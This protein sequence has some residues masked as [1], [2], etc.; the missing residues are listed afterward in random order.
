MSTIKSLFNYLESEEIYVDKDEFDFQFNSHPDFPSLLALSDTLTFFNIKNGAFKVNKSEIDLLPNKF[1]AK[2]NKGNSDFLSYVQKM[3]DTVIYSNGIAKN[4]VSKT[5]FEALWSDIVLLA[6]NEG[7]PPKAKSNTKH[8]Y[9][10]PLVTLVLITSVIILTSPKNW[11]LF[12]YALPILG[13][14][15]SIAVLKDLLGTKN[16]LLNKFCNITTNTSCNTIV[17]SNKWKI[18]DIISFSDLS[19]IFFSAQLVCLF[20]MGL[21]NLYADYFSI[22][23]IMLISAFPVITVSIYYQKYIEKKWCP[24]CLAIIGIVLL[25]LSA[26][27]YL[28]SNFSFNISA[29]GALLYL[30]TFAL[31]STIWLPLKKTLKKVNDLKAIELKANRFKRNYV[32]FKIMLIATER[33]DLPKCALIFGNPDAMLNISI[34]TS[35]F[36]GYCKEP[37]YMLKSILEKYGEQLNISIFY[38][39]NPTIILLRDFTLTISQ[40]K[41]KKGEESFLEAMDYW[42]KVKDI[43]NRKWFNKYKVDNEINE[44]ERLMEIQRKWFL[45]NSINFTP[46]LFVSGYRY[47]KEYNI[48]DLPFFIEELLEDQSFNN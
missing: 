11:L 5:D 24:L 25:E 7:T 47:P 13:T 4:I 38:N 39:V 35:P 28:N 19:I 34:V 3:N 42:Y 41:I 37:H 8:N 16:E 29:L 9:I 46:C 17:N 48:T 6:E 15:L 36:C 18:F 27:F 45:R 40:L 31:L 10:L 23:T 21:I 22:Q 33:Y 14:L 43:D 20:L 26:V 1:F 12:F 2:L 32:V 30:A 44:L